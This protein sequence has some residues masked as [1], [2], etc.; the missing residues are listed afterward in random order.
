M[1]LPTGS[2]NRVGL[3]P[4]RLSH[5]RRGRPEAS[6]GPGTSPPTYDVSPFASIALVRKTISQAN[7]HLFQIRNALRS[8]SVFAFFRIARSCASPSRC[9]FQSLLLRSALASDRASERPHHLRQRRPRTRPQR[10]RRP[11]RRQQ[12]PNYRSRRLRSCCCVRPYSRSI[13]A[14]AREIIPSCE[15]WAHPYSSSRTRRCDLA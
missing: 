7:P 12:R 3:P 15:I 1:Q 2:L 6:H 4:R 9:G 13:T 10:Q 14:F 11:A 5:A 8:G